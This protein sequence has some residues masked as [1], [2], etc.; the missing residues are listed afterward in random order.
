[1]AARRIDGHRPLPV[2]HECPFTLDDV[3]AEGRGSALMPV[4]AAADLGVDRR[5]KPGDDVRG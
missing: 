5:V 2:P 4:R 3:L 1:V